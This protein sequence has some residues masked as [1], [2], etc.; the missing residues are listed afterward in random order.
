MEAGW[1]GERE[2]KNPTDEWG[3]QFPGVA[4]NPYAWRRRGMD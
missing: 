1:R 3:R 4:L 2:A